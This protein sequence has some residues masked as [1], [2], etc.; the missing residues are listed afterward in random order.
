MK[1]ILNRFRRRMAQL[2]STQAYQ[3]WAD[4]YPAIAHNPLMEVE[5]AT[6]EAM[7]PDLVNKAI[8]DLACGTGRYGNLAVEKGA[9]LVVGCDNSLA[10]LQQAVIPMRCAAE[11]TDLP[12]PSN[13]FDVVLCGMAIGHTPHIERTLAAMGRVLKAG[14]SLLISDFHPRQVQLGHQRTFQ[15]D[16]GKVYA[17]EHYVHQ[18]AH[19]ESLAR[20]YKLQLSEIKE[21]KISGQTEPVV[22]VY[23]FK[24]TRI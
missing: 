12:F 7:M 6:L 1:R 5:Q 8:L 19:V 24:K 15:T 10:M 22:V 17:I 3:L 23:R 20:K 14:G 18:P 21:P 2:P 16:D 4:R 9:A 11:L 13:N